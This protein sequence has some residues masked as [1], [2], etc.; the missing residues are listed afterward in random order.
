[1][2]RVRVL[3]VD[4]F[5]AFRDSVISMVPTMPQLQVV[6]VAS[7]GLEAVRKARELQPDLI[8][9]DIQL[10]GQN[11]FQ[12]A[13]QIRQI[14]PNCKIIFLTQETSADVVQEALR[15]GARGYVAKICAGRDLLAAIEAVL[16]DKQFVSSSLSPHNFT[17]SDD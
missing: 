2:S 3:V 8:L 12:A 10:P 9:L 11:G 5:E 4:D 6:G 14:A 1:M 17:H 15:L 7:D 13:R 16:G